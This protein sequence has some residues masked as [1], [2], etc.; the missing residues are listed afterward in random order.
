[1]LL[2]KLNNFLERAMS[3]KL[4]TDGTIAQDTTQFR[5]LWQIRES[6]AEAGAKY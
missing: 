4:V 6:F 1:V 3:E 5:T 2:Q